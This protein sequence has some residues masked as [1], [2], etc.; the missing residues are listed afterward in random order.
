MSKFHVAWRKLQ[1]LNKKWP[2]ILNNKKVQI[3]V[4]VKLVLRF[5]VEPTRG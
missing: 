4:H 5:Y 3:K 1:P 2:K